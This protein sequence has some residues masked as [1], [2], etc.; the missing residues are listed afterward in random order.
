MFIVFIS[1]F[2]ALFP[3]I[4]D[5]I[6]RFFRFFGQFFIDDP[7]RSSYF[8]ISR[9]N[10]L[11]NTSLFIGS[12]FFITMLGGIIF[13]RYNFKVKNIDIR[14]KNWSSKLKGFKIVHINLVYSKLYQDQLTM[15]LL[16]L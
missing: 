3:I 2:F 9:L 4:L 1:K 5:D 15:L 12:T 6:I 10:F 7:N 16:N 14:L 8:N 13:G 11:K